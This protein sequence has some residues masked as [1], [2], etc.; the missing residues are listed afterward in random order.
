MVNSVI[1]QMWDQ[2]QL[3]EQ[4]IILNCSVHVVNSIYTNQFI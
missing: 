3:I 4:V 2:Y 1:K